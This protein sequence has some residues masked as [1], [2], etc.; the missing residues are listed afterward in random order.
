[1]QSYSIIL[2]SHSAI[3]PLASSFGKANNITKQKMEKALR[4]PDWAIMQSARYTEKREVEGI[5]RKLSRLDLK[6]RHV[7]SGI[8]TIQDHIERKTGIYTPEEAENRVANYREVIQTAIRS[9]SELETSLNRITLDEEQSEKTK[10][11]FEK[12]HNENIK[13]STFADWLR[14]VEILTV[15]VYPSE[16]WCNIKVTIAIDLAG[17]DG[18]SDSTLCYNTNIA[19]PKL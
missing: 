13:R 9:E 8:T 4:N 15:R 5:K 18:D 12:V 10:E 14:I 7:E 17:L 11:A 19:S 6:A 16:D 3:N 2:F 1:M